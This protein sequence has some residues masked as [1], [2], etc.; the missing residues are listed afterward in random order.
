[1]RILEKCAAAW[2]IPEIQAQI[3]SLRVAFSAD[4]SKPFEL[5]RTFPYGSPSESQ[6]SPPPFDGHYNNQYA[7]T[8]SPSQQIAFTSHPITPPA[9][10]RAESNPHSPPVSNLS[11]MPHATTT[12]PLTMPL[13]D[14]NSWDPTRIMTYV[15][16]PPTFGCCLLTDSS[17]SWDLAFAVNSSQFGPS[18]P[19]NANQM[20]DSMPTQYTIQYPAA[21]KVM[22]M[23]ASQ[24]AIREQQ[25]VAQAPVMM[26][27]RDWQQSVASVYDPHGIKRRW[28]YSVDLTHGSSR[29]G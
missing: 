18:S 7:Q 17:R 11:M 16:L 12:Q 6:A 24:A 15:H 13:V 9:S 2:P 23:D 26:T 22:S 27:A 21:G 20:V 5:K 3:E 29:P 8:S 1:M 19:M 10:A 4:T 14:E 28:N 25:P